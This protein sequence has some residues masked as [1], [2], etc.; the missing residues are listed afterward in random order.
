M[1]G[2]YK[3]TSPIGSVYVGQSINIERRFR[4]YKNGTCKSQRL[5]NGSFE[6]YGA[7]NHSFD[8]ITECLEIELNELE[9]YY[10]EIYNV[11]GSKGLNCVYTKANKRRV[12]LSDDT[13]IKKRNSALGKVT[14]IETKLKLS[15]ARIGKKHSEETK[16]KMKLA[17][18]NMS[19]ETKEKLIKH[20]K[21]RKNKSCKIVLDTQTGIFYESAKEASLY[22]IYKY[23]IITNYLNG[24]RK[25]KTNL[26]YV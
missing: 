20:Y 5:L 12:V 13:I 14:S 18:L 22:S 16:N 2:I 7:K 10:Q 1:I 3:I 26:I 6:K 24:K 25:N 9:R 21:E 15:I 23:D 19:L 4:I 17:K 11:L 8:I